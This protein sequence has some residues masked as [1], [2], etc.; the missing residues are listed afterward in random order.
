MAACTIC[1][2][3][4]QP[5]ALPDVADVGRVPC[6]VRRF[7][8]NVFTMWRCAGCGSVHCAED[9]DLPMYYADYPLKAQ[10]LTFSEKV[11]YGNRM[12]LLER[13]GIRRNSRILD[14]GCG[15]GLFVKFLQEKGFENVSGY[16]AFVPEYSVQ[17]R[18][19]E[20]YDAVVSYDVIEHADDTRDFM[21]SLARL[22]RPGGLLVIGTPNADNVPLERTKDP[23]LHPPYHRHILS[24][25]VLLALGREQNLEPE[26]IYRRSFY[27]SLVPTVNSRFMW[28][29]IQKT[30][31]LLDA[32]VEPPQAG[33]V[34][35][36]PEMLF[37]AFFGYFRPLGD[38]MLVTFRKLGKP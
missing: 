3:C 7:K 22:V 11:G 14:Y 20:S 27:D 10:K 37:L 6:N 29:Y 21:A 8:E 31:G 34:L 13:Q 5:A 35:K 9:A 24:E 30:G 2:L 18:L 16:D 28:Q 26:H 1:N 12:R 33:L 15:A 25:K 23:S 38:N 17:Y 32:A 4:D 36:S 19:D